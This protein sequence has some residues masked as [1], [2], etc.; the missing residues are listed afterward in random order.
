MHL[1]EVYY[2]I[3]HKTCAS[4]NNRDLKTVINTIIAPSH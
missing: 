1:N 4:T 2:F 3:R